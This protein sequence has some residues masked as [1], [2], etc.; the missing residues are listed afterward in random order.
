MV[1]NTKCKRKWFQFIPLIDISTCFINVSYHW[2]NKV[3]F[4]WA[5]NHT[6]S[7]CFL[8]PS[9]ILSTKPSTWMG[10]LL[11]GSSIYGS[12]EVQFIT[13]YG[14]IIQQIMNLIK[15]IVL[16]HNRHIIAKFPFVIYTK[17]MKRF[18]ANVQQVSFWTLKPF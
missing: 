4:I 8:V 7:I 6:L 13:P 9:T 15:E 12:F 14:N 18:N 2:K 5:Q 3:Q 16:V 1:Q 17:R 11:N 10:S